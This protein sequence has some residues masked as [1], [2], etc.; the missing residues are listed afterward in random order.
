MWQTTSDKF[1]YSPQTCGLPLALVFTA[2]LGLG[3]CG[4]GGGGGGGGGNTGNAPAT[5]SILLDDNPAPAQASFENFTAEPLQLTVM[6][7]LAGQQI[8]FAG[9]P[10]FLKLA[11]SDGLASCNGNASDDDKLLFLGEVD[12]DQPLDLLVDLPL[13]TLAV[14]YEIF[15]PLDDTLFGGITL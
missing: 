11:R 7:I 1:R 2:L 4:G 10:V 3:G 14:C 15:S 5:T 9:T 13:D 8:T 6:D 12:P